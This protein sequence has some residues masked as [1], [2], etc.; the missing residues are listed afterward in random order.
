MYFVFYLFMINE[1][2]KKI[3]LSI[4]FHP[5]LFTNLMACLEVV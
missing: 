5:Y 4:G 1:I 3:Y 2:N